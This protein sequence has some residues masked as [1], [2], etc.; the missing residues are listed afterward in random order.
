VGT[1]IL[2]QTGSNRESLV[3]QYPLGLVSELRQDPA[4]RRYGG[5]LMRR[6]R[7]L[8]A[9]APQSRTRPSAGRCCWRCWVWPGISR[10]PGPGLSPS[11]VPGASTPRSGKD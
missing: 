1:H 8:P 11:P 4:D 10:R 7:C 6:S 2:G 9:T 3:E 5:V